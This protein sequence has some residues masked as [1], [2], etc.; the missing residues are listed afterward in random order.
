[1][2]SFQIRPYRSA[3]RHAV[4]ELLAGLP[5]LYPDATSWLPN[6][7]DDCAAGRAQCFVAQE[8]ADL[9]GVVI[10]SPKSRSRLKISTIFV[11]PQARRH[12]VGEALCDTA[13]SFWTQG[14]YEDVYVTVAPVNLEGVQALFEPYG[15]RQDAV[16]E[17]RYEGRDEI[18][19]KWQQPVA[20][21]ALQSVHAQRIYDGL[22]HYEFR[23]VFVRLPVGTR[24]LIYESGRVGQVTGEF[25]VASLVHGTPDQV[26]Q[27]EQDR[28]S[29]E[30]ARL[31]L[32][33]ATRATALQVARSCRYDKPLAL[34]ELGVSRAP[35][36]YLRLA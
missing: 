11:S 27:L 8:G 22:K 3:D 17:G 33:G 13:A 5:S 14:G 15:F 31:Y 32:A 28:Q 12:G 36:S 18:V 7:L 6:R 35:Q 21:F 25:L 29:R 23:R 20:L 16:L 10:L 19:L 30:D 26:V 24:V 4:S 9:V 1:M 34:S 2:S